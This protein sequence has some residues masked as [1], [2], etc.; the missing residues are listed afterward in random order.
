[1]K[2]RALQ[3]ILEDTKNASKSGMFGLDACKEA[4]IFDRDFFHKSLYQQLE[5]YVKRANNEPL[6]ND[7]MV[8]AC[9]QLINE[10]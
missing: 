4:I 10:Q 8:Q 7:N 9:W 3:Q 2:Q 6:F 1:M 5:E